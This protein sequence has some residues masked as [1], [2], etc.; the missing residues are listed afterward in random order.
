MW[1][2]SRVGTRFNLGVGKWRAQANEAGRPN[3]PSE[4]ERRS[5]GDLETWSVW[6]C[7]LASGR[8]LGGSAEASFLGISFQS[9]V[10]RKMFK[11]NVL[12]VR[13]KHI[14]NHCEQELILQ[15]DLRDD[16]R[17]YPTS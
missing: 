15:L 14:E 11:L 5:R 4:Y 7:G 6:N 12:R 17:Y 10:L 8:L 13:L 9:S 2:F 3:I 16:V 1:A